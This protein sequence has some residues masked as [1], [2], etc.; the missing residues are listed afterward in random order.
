[1]PRAKPRILFHVG[2]P[3]FH[4]VAE[5]AACI[6]AWLGGEYVCEVADG[7]A[8]FERLDACDLFVIMGLQWT[9]QQEVYVPLTSDDRGAFERYVASGKPLLTHHGGVASYDDW[10]Q[11]GELL[12]WTWVWGTTGHSPVAE[13][14]VDVLPTAHPIVAGVSDFAL[15]DELYHSVKVTEGM[16]HSVHAQAHWLERT[17]PMVSTAEGGRVAGAGR[18]AYLANGH[19]MRAFEAP[20]LRQLWINAARWLLDLIP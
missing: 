19:D 11:F 16:H 10:P 6:A 1:M 7:R 18:A 8:A 4:P 20:A 14:K 13:H 15:V 9:G 5:Q 2:G 12:G 3:A 17:L